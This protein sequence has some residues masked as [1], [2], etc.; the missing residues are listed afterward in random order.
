MDFATLE[1]IR[2]GVRAYLREQHGPGDLSWHPLFSA[3]LD[4]YCFYMEA[5]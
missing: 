1:T 2:I 3:T 4:L 5:L